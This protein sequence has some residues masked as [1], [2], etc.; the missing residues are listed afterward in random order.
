MRDF[1]LLVKELAAANDEYTGG[2]N[3]DDDR[4]AAMRQLGAVIAHL[5]TALPIGG[6]E[7]LE[8]LRGLYASLWDLDFGNRVPDMIQKRNDLRQDGRPSRSF[9]EQ[10]RLEKAAA[11]VTILKQAGLSVDDAARFVTRRIIRGPK[12]TQKQLINYRKRTDVDH[13]VREWG[14]IRNPIRF[15]EGSC[16]GVGGNLK[17]A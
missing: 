10:I 1:E 17:A 3:A 16:L 2:W 11:C 8:P 12:L 5:Q 14:E 6:P 9:D 7:T 4:Y 13:W 15:V